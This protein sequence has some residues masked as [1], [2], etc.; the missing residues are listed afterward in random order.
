MKWT[1]AHWCS[2]TARGPS[3]LHTRLPFRRSSALA[4]SASAPSTRCDRLRE[5][6]PVMG[7]EKLCELQLY[8]YI[9]ILFVF[10]INSFYSQFSSFL[11]I[12]I[13]LRARTCI[14][15][16]LYILPQQQ[17]SGRRLSWLFQHCKGELRT[18]CFNKPYILQVL[19]HIVV[20]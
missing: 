6:V 11:Y 5:A 4:R 9:Y 20:D 13:P 17:H 10:I 2:P 15:T 3:L 16:C 7:R 18:S 8:I 1:L 19:A 14:E 12:L